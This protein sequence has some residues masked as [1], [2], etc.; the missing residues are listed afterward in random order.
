MNTKTEN[1]GVDML[2]GPLLK[3]ILLFA[4]PLAASSVLQQFF[5]SADVAVVGHFAG[6]EA[7]A[8]VGS[9][10]PIINLLIN[11]FVGMSVGANVVIGMFLGQKKEEQVSR[12][13]HTVMLLSVVTGIILIFIGWFL[14]APL[15]ELIKTP[16][17]VIGLASVYLR[18]YFMGMPFFMFYNFGAAVLRSRGDT[19]RPLL[20]LIV[21]GVV[22]VLLNLF[23]V[24]VL[25]M[26]VAGVG[27]A[28]L[29]AN[30][31]SAS[32]IACFLLGERSSLRLYPSKLSFN[33]PILLR[34]IKIGVPAGIQ[35]MIFS[36]SN[37][38]IQSAINSFG[39]DAMAGSAAAQNFEFFSYFVINSF[40][41][42]AVTFISQNFGA[43]K[44]DRCS[45]VYRLC[46][47]SSFVMTGIMSSSFVLGRN[48]FLRFYTSDESVLVYGAMRL[49]F[50]ESF[51]AIPCSYEISAS[52]LRGMGYSML[53][54]VLTMIGSCLLRI[55]WLLTV[56]KI[57]PDFR[58]LMAVYP[59]SWLITGIMLITAYIIIRKKLVCVQTRKN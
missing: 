26:G 36:F 12:A 28:T 4:L 37:V 3:K 8:A 20:C 47:I 49:V 35:G 14:T 18:I 44:M 5:N 6:S 30:A 10:T 55:V 15:L 11:I 42:A 32:M 46:M 33:V 31:V 17:N 56:F 22:N 25:G 16:E 24:I 34:V 38:C 53:P 23:F 39:P 52:A 50:I 9:N 58:V 29:I 45:K 41:Q 59:F 7:L 43:G 48:I 54:A 40:N 13:V 1:S 19:N 2:N 57:F 21:S 27:I 51:G